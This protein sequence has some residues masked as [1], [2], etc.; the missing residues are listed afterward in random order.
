MATKYAVLWDIESAKSRP[1]GL[2]IDGENGVTVELP[3]DYG[4]PRTYSDEFRVLKGGQDIVYTPGEPAYFEQVLA[5]LSTAVAVS[6]RGEIEA[7]TPEAVLDLMREKV[8]R[9]GQQA[10][11]VGHYYV[12]VENYVTVENVHAGLIGAGARYGTGRIVVSD[13]VEVEPADDRHYVVA[14]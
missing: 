5:D 4:L 14:A 2:A 11:A 7:Q 6:E 13:D 10:A 8:N 3:S 9:P 12:K 1:I